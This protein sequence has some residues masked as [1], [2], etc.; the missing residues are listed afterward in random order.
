MAEVVR[1]TRKLELDIFELLEQFREATTLMPTSISLQIVGWSC[2][3]EPEQKFTKKV[4][5]QV[6]L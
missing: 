5:V 4:E 3:D 6:C 1:R 2:V